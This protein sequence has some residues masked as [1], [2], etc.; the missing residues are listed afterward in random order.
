MKTYP[1]AIYDTKA[2]V[3]F[4]RAKATSLASIR[5]ASGWSAISPARTFRRWSRLQARSRCSRANTAPI[6]NAATS[7]KVKAVVGFY[8]V[9][10]M[11]AQWEH[12]RSRGRATRSPRISLALSP[13]TNRQVFFEA[14][15][16]SYA[17]V[18]RIDP[19]PADPRH[20]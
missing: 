1:G 11:L 16:M 5:S 20:R 2:A 6:R 7:A 19:L 12:D 14:S 15:P 4:V 8:G 17:T 9:Y 13:H 10:D 18:D 3:Q